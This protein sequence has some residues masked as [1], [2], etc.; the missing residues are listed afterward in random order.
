METTVADTPVHFLNIEYFFRL[1]YELV[2]QSRGFAFRG[3]LLELAS[4]I[5]L[6]FTI[7]SL[8][9]SIV[10]L[11]VFVNATIRF[12]Q[13][14]RDEEEKYSTLHPHEAEE[15][16]DH[17]RWNHVRQMVES[18]NENDWRQAIIE[19]DIMLDDLL[20]QLGYPGQS[21]GEKLRAVDPSRFHSLQYAWDAHKVRNEIAHSGTGYRLDE[22][23]AHR[24]IAMY[25]VVMREHGEIQ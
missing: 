24:T 1:L 8:L 20:S 16:R 18:P 13:T 21:V 14:R 6:T 4:T 5:W 11:V 10:L 3:D 15:R 7:L 23:Q 2:T 12:H 17:S 25:E 22:R 19:A 9:V